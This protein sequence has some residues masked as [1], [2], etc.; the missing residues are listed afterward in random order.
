VKIVL[1]KTMK[2]QT[3]AGRRGGFILNFGDANT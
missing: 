3:T 1:G 2:R